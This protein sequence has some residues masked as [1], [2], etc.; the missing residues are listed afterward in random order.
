MRWSARK[1]IEFIEARLYWEKKI[2]RKDLAD[3]F[4]ISIPQATKDIKEYSELAPENI[5][6][7]ASAKQYVATKDFVPKML[8]PSSEG[9]LARLKSLKFRGDDQKFFNGT[10]PPFYVMPN[11]RRFVDTKILQRILETIRNNE[12]VKINYQSMSSPQP[13]VRWISP[14]SLA[15]D[16]S[17]WHV[18]SLCHNDRKYK[19]FN[20]GRI[21]NILDSREHLFD[22]SIDYKW[23]NEIEIIIAPHPLLDEGHKSLIERDYCMDNGQVVVSI[24]AAFFYYYTNNFGLKSGHEKLSPK[25]Q[26]IILLNLEETNTKVQMLKSM[27]EQ[28]LQKLPESSFIN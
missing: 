21:L 2:S 25:E 28:K 15:Y 4:D 26:Q 7:D 22:H 23:H 5:I 27:T 12:A 3:F 14:H 19:D 17:R 6:Y 24:K 10:I 13:S 16:G 8:E 9:Y 20:L 1:R 11:L 18:R